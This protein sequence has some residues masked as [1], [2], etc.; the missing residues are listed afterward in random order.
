MD[1]NSQT[2]SL[3]SKKILLRITAIVL[4]AALVLT[5]V[6]P[7]FAAQKSLS[8]D[9]DFSDAP[10]V[11]ATTALLIDAGS[12]EVLYAKNADARRNPASITKILT[13]LVVVENAELNQQVTVDYPVD[14]SESHMGL[15][16]GE[17]L[18]I[19]Q[20]LY[21][22]MMESAN[23]AA[24]L[25]AVKVG[26]DMQTFCKM[27]NDRAAACGAEN[28]NFT[29]PSGLNG[30][31]QEGH[32]TTAYDLTKIMKEG[33][34]NPQFREIITAKS[35][36]IPATNKSELRKLKSTNLCFY[37]SVKDETDGKVRSY[38]YDGC[39]A[40]KTGYTSESG[41]CYCGLAVRGDTELIVVVLNSKTKDTRFT[42]AIKLWDYGFS[43][44][45]TYTAQKA[46][47][48]VNDIRVKKGKERRVDVWLEE[49]LDITLN[50]GYDS[51]NIST[52]VVYD[53]KKIEAP[54]KKGTVVGS[55]LVYKEKQMIARADLCV[56][57]SVE[58]GNLFSF[59]KNLFNLKVILGVLLVLM[60]AV[61]VPAAAMQIRSAY[62]SS[63]RK[64]RLRKRAVRN[65]K[66]RRRQWE[67][68][69]NP[70]R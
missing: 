43:K 12:G 20:L 54:V 50:N 58:E 56:A 3:K 26:G 49:D 15:K 69:K 33:M 53:T 29:N 11:A 42:D 18:T 47:V 5:G 41:N 59:I 14:Q 57:Q 48:A 19:K 31:G 35:Y 40:G 30:P 64:R 32:R 7:S 4:A 44:Y 66:A 6:T 34:K 23:D 16:Q 25:L 38:K 52:E 8:A 2:F 62:I 60:A 65:R 22:M 1:S 39:I 13:C 55:V 36:T 45:Y 68:E 21:A 67:K 10:D 17:V 63:R 70:F 61:L 51:S 9:I 46:G 27:M 37:P 24:E 28:T